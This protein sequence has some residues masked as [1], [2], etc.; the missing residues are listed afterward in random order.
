MTY[1]VFDFDISAQKNVYVA[2]EKTCKPK[3]GFTTS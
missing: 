2:L 3:T 1:C